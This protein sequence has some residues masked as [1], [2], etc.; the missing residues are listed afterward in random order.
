ME[1]AFRDGTID[2]D[3]LRARLDI[4]EASRAKLRYIHLAAHL[5]TVK[6]LN[7]EQIAR[8]NELRGST[9]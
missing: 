6:L 5:E 2:A 7:R 3:Q 8:Y 4:I 9:R 1:A